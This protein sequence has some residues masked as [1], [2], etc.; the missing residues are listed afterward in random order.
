MS[1]RSEDHPPFERTDGDTIITAPGLFLAG[2][3][4]CPHPENGLW[5]GGRDAWSY[6]TAGRLVTRYP[7]GWVLLGK[8][9][10][11]YQLT[12]FDREFNRQVTNL[13]SI[14]NWLMSQAEV[15]NAFGRTHDACTHIALTQVNLALWFVTEKGRGEIE[16]FPLVGFDEHETE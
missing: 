13:Q 3:S 9:T 16:N 12:W 8:F 15:V 6:N 7:A 10:G 1:K 5:I 2:A 4:S 11:P 14:R